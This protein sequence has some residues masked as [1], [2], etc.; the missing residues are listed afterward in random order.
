M[1][2]AKDTSA[3][4]V[5]T[6]IFKAARGGGLPLGYAEDLAAAARY[7]NL[8]DLTKCPCSGDM[9]DVAAIQTALDF[10]VAGDGPQT[11]K[12]DEALITAFVASAEA[13][14][15]RTLVWTAT[16]TGAVF[17]RFETTPPDLKNLL[18]RRMIAPTLTAHLTEMAEK[19]LVPETETSRLSGAGA[20]LADND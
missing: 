19:L 18:G 20:G 9:S 16:T 3:N 1:T 5:E 7:L 6:L 4:E 13:M 2:A 14:W 11:V 17:E 12:G 15:D 10:V 8:N